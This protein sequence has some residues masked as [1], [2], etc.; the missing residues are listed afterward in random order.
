MKMPRAFLR[1]SAAVVFLAIV[2]AQTAGHAGGSSRGS[3]FECVVAPSEAT[4]ITLDCPNEF[5]TTT[6]E[7]AIAVDPTDH[8]HIVTASLNERWPNQT[9]QIATSF[10][11][12]D[13]WTIADLPRRADEANWDPWLSFDQRR[14]TVILAFETT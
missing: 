2:A 12:G 4:N 9:I 11:G 5:A 13:S 1:I 6:D 3:G 14:G 8:A 7:P 10:D